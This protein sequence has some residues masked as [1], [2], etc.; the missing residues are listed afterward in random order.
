MLRWLC[1][2]MGVCSLLHAQWDGPYENL[3]VLP[4]DIGKNELRDIMRQW[5][6]DLGVRCTHCHATP[7]GKFEDIDFAS[8]DRK[9]K[10]I[11][12]EM[13]KMTRAVNKDFFKP[14]DKEISCY[15]CH[16]GTTDPRPLET[17]LRAGYDEGG[18]DQLEKT[19]REK[20]K[21]YHGAG[22]YNFKPWSALSVVANSLLPNE[23]WPDLKKIHLLNLEFNPDYDG[24][25]FFLGAYYLDVEINET[26][27]R[28]HLT[29][30]MRSNA[31]WTPRKSARLAKK[32]AH[33]QKSEA[34]ER[35]L[36][37]MVA[38][39]PNHADTHANLGIYLKINGRMEEAGQALQKALSLKPDHPAAKPALAEMEQK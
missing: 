3:K 7:T 16:H 2:M 23:N 28:D 22:A 34:A 19:Y 5:S 18:I 4:E 36:R 25:H 1:L 12:R 32:W 31:F 14:H 17:I 26:L 11:A 8:D 24:S 27:A 6:M 29:A 30:A 39:A 35:L 33:Q 37:M 9:P 38:V 13:L 15:T 20:R 21:T 10:K